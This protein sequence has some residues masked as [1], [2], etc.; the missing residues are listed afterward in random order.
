MQ[1]GTAL[2]RS[3]LKDASIFRLI[4]L[5]RGLLRLCVPVAFLATALLY[6]LSSLLSDLE[7]KIGLNTLQARHF[8]LAA[9]WFPL[10]RSHRSGPAYLEIKTGNVWGI[11]AVRQALKY[12]PYAADLLAGL[13]QMQLATRD[14]SGYSASMAQLHA[15][16]GVK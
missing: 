14:V 6:G 7:Y 13:A 5:L 1:R 10:L 11:Q 9:R 12:D 3:W 15:L 16:P 8:E 4:A 2:R